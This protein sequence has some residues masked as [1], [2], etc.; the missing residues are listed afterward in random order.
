MLKT[1]SAEELYAEESLGVRARIAYET[2]REFLKQ[3]RNEELVGIIQ[4]YQLGAEGLGARLIPR[5]AALYCL[6]R[7]ERELRNRIASGD[8]AR[9]EIRN[10]RT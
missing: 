6:D 10:A 9:E 7:I 4:D 1:K 8:S 2:N 5:A 3:L